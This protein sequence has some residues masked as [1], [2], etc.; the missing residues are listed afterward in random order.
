MC[1]TEERSLCE[2]NQKIIV[3]KDNGESREHRAI[4]PDR[5]FEVRQY[6]LDGDILKQTK[7]CDFLLLND[8]KKNAYLIEL[9]G[10]K[11]D[12]AI[13]QLLAGE[14][15]CRKYFADY[16]FLYRIVCSKVKTHKLN[17]N[18]VRKFLDQHPGRVIIK[19]PKIKE[20][21]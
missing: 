8:T 14:R 7:T 6:K 3:S 15:F 17:A 13:D 19:A 20:N 1:F 4:N 12:D 2:K 5:K 10:K 11:N 18:K 9:K 21:L 16:T